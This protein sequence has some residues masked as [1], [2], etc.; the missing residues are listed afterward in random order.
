M[1]SSGR[2]Q[3]KTAKFPQTFEEFAAMAETALEQFW[4]SQ[5]LNDLFGAV[6]ATVHAADWYNSEFGSGKFDKEAKK[7][8]GGKCDGWDTL[9]RL[10]NGAKHAVKNTQP[11]ADDL[12]SND[13]EWE[14][15]DAWDHLGMDIPYWTVEH[16]GE[17]RSVYSLCHQ[18]LVQLKEESAAA[19]AL[20]GA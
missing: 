15:K 11:S 16:K 17:M 8:F 5:S 12:T 18:V 4:E 14:D 7:Q 6:L 20:R 10:G 9:R 19:K 2:D 13:V 3:A 1:T